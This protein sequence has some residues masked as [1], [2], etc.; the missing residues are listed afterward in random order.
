MD[1]CKRS[2][3]AV[4]E[5]QIVPQLVRAHAEQLA[6]G[7]ALATQHLNPSAST[8]AEF[9]NLCHHED[10]T[11]CWDFVERLVQQR[12]SVP[13]VLLNLITPAARYLGEMWEQDRLDFSHVTLALLRMQNMTHHYGFL[14]RRAHHQAGPKLR[15][16][17]AAAPGSQHLL[18]LAMVSEFFVN[19]GWDVTVD[20][21][22]S[23]HDLLQ[24]V[25]KDWFEVVGLSVG[26]L[27]Q[28]DTLPALVKA[29]R[30]HSHNPKVVVLLGGAAFS[31]PSR[32]GQVD[33][34]DAADGADTAYGA[35]AVCLAPLEAM[36]IARELASPA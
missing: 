33:T 23:E 7:P 3:L 12:H 5:S 26:L 21:A 35:D 1:A 34:A 15:A 22:T 2:L 30:Q 18:G 36:R 4:I 29:L 10:E 19:D 28:L 20:V 17:V 32:A 6:T 24:A 25:S 16:L 9:A 31:H 11:A 8:M 27:E 13:E 14:N